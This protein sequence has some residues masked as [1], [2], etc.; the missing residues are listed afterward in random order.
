M[1]TPL[2]FIY[3]LAD[4]RTEAVRY[5]GQ[6]S[7][8]MRRPR[9]HFS[10][11]KSSGGTHSG[12]W[13]KSLRSVGL[14]PSVRILEE[15]PVDDL[16]LA[17]MFWIAQAKGIGWD[18]TNHTD[19]GGGLRG[20]RH[21]EKTK[22]RIRA[23]NT[24][25]KR[26]PETRALIGLLAKG[27]TH[28][29][30]TRLKLR[31][32]HLGKKYAPMSAQGRAN[33]AAAQRGKKRGPRS[34]EARANMSAA[35]RAMPLPEFCGRGHPWAPETTHGHGT[36]HRVFRYCMAC[37]KEDR[38]KLSAYERVRRAARRENPC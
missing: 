21:N 27:R 15:V 19:G 38:A 24:G 37:R 29:A 30:E 2:S 3:A 33:L 32:G 13:I 6:T 25:K 8:G 11:S 22:E 18:L 7:N 23:A 31:L 9:Y 10:P 16:N 5:V 26:S 14:R 36:G 12:N 17:E 34:A 1:T 20:F 35:Q 4:P 28:S